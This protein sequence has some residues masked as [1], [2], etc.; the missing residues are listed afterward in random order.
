MNP[1]ICDA[2]GKALSPNVNKSYK[3][4]GPDEL[5]DTRPFV[6]VCPK[7][8]DLAGFSL[9]RSNVLADANK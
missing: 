1:H 9:A 4:D 2:C 6:Y 7:C 8:F 3:G 5:M